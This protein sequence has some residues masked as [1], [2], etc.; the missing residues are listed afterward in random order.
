LLPEVLPLFEP[1]L[2]SEGKFPPEA[3]LESGGKFPPEPPD[4]PLA[5]AGS[6]GGCSAD[7]STDC[8]PP[9]AESSLFAAPSFVLGCSLAF[10]FEASPASDFE[11]ALTS[12]E[13][14]SSDPPTPLPSF[15]AFFDPFPPPYRYAHG[16]LYDIIYIGCRIEF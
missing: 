3:T 1:A 16:H 14:G 9:E 2:E 10:P 12:S 15:G 11:F 8:F 6:P 7:V 4:V 13:E 5:S